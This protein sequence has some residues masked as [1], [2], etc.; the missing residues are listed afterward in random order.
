MPI[1]KNAIK[2]MRQDEKREEHNKAQRSHMRTMLK[3]AVNLKTPEALSIAFSALDKAA[4]THLIH[5]GKANR[6][7]SRLTKAIAKVVETAVAAKP[8]TAKS[9]KKAVTKKAAAKKAATK[10]VAKTA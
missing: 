9:T 7:K 4:K 2:K 3:H 6:L 10:K 1:L 5:K 8:K